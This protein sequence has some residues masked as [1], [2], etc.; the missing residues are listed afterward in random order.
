MRCK[1]KSVA[2]RLH[3]RTGPGVTFKEIGHRGVGDTFIATKSKKLSNGEV[4]YKEEN[5]NKWSCAKTK[6]G[7]VYIKVIKDLEGKTV[8]QSLGD[9]PKGGGGG[10]GGTNPVKPVHSGKVINDVKG[11]IGQGIPKEPS[12]LVKNPI[13]MSRS[14]AKSGV[15]ELTKEERDYIDL[16]DTKKKPVVVHQSQNFLSYSSGNFPTA[17]YI[18]SHSKNAHKITGPVTAT[19]EGTMTIV[20]SAIH[21]RIYGGKYKGWHYLGMQGG[22]HV[23]CN[24]ANMSV[25]YEIRAKENKLVDETDR[26]NATKSEE[27]KQKE[28]TTNGAQLTFD[29]DAIR[30]NLNVPVGMQRV[31]LNHHTYLNFNRFRIQYPDVYLK[32]AV[33]V[34]FFTRPDLNILDDVPT[35]TTKP[36]WGI[37]GQVKRDIR[38]YYILLQNP[39]LAG[40]LTQRGGN[41]SQFKNHNFNILLSNLA[42]GIEVVDDSVD[43]LEYGETY[44]GYKMHYSKSNTKSTAA[45]T[46]NIKFKETYD[47]AV[48][49]LHQ[50][51]VDYQ[52]NVYKG[53]FKPKLAH[54]WAKELDYACN[55]YYF[56]L[57]SDMETILFWTKYYGCFPANVPKSTFSYDFG[58]NVQFPDVSVT[59]NYIYKSDLS[60]QALV[61]FNQDGGAGK[62]PFQYAPTFVKSKYNYDVGCYSWA[63]VPYVATYRDTENANMQ[64]HLPETMQKS[65]KLRLRYR[66][67]G[68]Y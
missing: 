46:L 10:K 51:W 27:D 42:Q 56:L 6:T 30:R 68:Q 29:M 67:Y 9:P 44:T 57:D 18:S 34:V 35:S 38:D 59:Y 47:L 63:G 66:K 20:M 61:E 32:N 15:A 28:V 55:I 54:I 64:R 22:K 21:G 62:I 8:S 12:T 36:K 19:I 2:S 11:N 13:R 37:K 49:N 16:G 58:S 40:C 24:P 48:T 14:S 53:I 7:K 43:L 41:A 39:V 31:T 17:E 25:D 23:I 1:V 50:L 45:G 60:P 52:S 33:G 5:K 4:W 65:D 26:K 3:I